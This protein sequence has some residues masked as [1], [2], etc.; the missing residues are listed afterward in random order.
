MACALG[1]NAQQ[2]VL[3]GDQKP[4]VVKHEY[5][6]NGK[7]R[8]EASFRDGKREGVWRE[9]DEQGN[10]VKS[11]TYQKGALVGEGIVGIDGYQWGKK[12]DFVSQLDQNLQMLCLFAKDHGKIAAL[13]ECGL[14]NL[15][16]PTWWTSTLQPV[17]DKYP[18]S[19]LLVWRNYEK[20]W[21]GPSPVKPDAPYF[22][23][24]HAADKTLFLKDIQ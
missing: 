19:Y 13:T 5:Y 8:R 18:I 16:D 12:E 6:P 17:V 7:V 3:E 1:V 24:F 9:F 22:K 2:Q 10:V 23:E 14:K 15:A 11:Q 4:L 21:F 20:E